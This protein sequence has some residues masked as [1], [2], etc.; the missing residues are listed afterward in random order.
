MTL[1]R[2]S[3]MSIN[4][5]QCRLLNTLVEG[6]ILPIFPLEEISDQTNK[7]YRNKSSA[8]LHC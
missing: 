5:T 2:P 4:T 1:S 7:L 8:S 3:E 6:C